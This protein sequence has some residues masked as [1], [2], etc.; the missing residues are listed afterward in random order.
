MKLLTT[1]SAVLVA[2]SGPALAKE[3]R[4][5]DLPSG[6]HVQLPPGCRDL[7]HAGRFDREKQD[8]INSSQGF[9][10]LGNGTQVRIGGR[11]RAEVGVRR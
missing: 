1:L 11:I 6:A 8:S 4:M 9:I 2:V 3:C 5:P 7:I 10:D